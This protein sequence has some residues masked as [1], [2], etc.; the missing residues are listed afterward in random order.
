MK[1]KLRLIPLLLAAAIAMSA[2]SGGG[3]Q[4]TSA[5]T[6]HSAAAIPVEVMTAEPASISK[7][8]TYVGKVAAN[9]TVDV[10]SKLSAQAKE[11]LVDVGDTVKKGQVLLILDDKDLRDQIKTSEAQLKVAN[12]GVQTA[13]TGLEQVTSGGQTA[14]QKLSLETAVK[15]AQ[16][17]VDNA[18]ISMENAKSSV[19]TSKIA[20]DNAQ[21]AFNDTQ[22][23]Y[24]D[25]KTMLDAGVI[26]QSDF[27]SIELGYNQ[28]KNALEQAQLGYSQTENAYNQAKNAYDTACTALEQAQSSLALFNEKTLQD[29]KENARNGVASANASRD[30]VL[31]SLNVLKSNLNYIQ[32]T[33]PIDGVITK[34]NVEPTNMVSAG[35]APF[36]VADTSKV[37]VNVD[38]SEKI[39]NS[40]N[41]GQTIGVNI[42]SVYDTPVNGVIKTIDPAAGSNGAF[43]V[44]IEIANTDGKLKP[45]M[46]AHVSFTEQESDN[47]F[48]V[49][50]NTVLEDNETKYVYVIDGVTAVK[51]PVTT[52]IDN[53]EN[54]EIS[55]VQSGDKIVVSGQSYLSDG[56][57]VIL[58]EE[59]EQETT[60]AGKEE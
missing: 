48:V 27:D 18:K 55:G 13:K 26:T 28:A 42:N 45:G 38:V 12:A 23:K 24:N 58:A 9:D 31:E 51:T 17:G 50:R 29:S 4:E 14:T 41:V 53:G 1:K 44:K 47:V 34:R 54:I 39:I 19:S 10:T 11:V 40:I 36:V 8:L 7:Y 15:N 43:T 5:Q 35:L 6:E 49:P 25:Y 20:M 56:S 22:K 2:C 30:S 46:I 3:S 60:T 32:V 16:T 52:G 37:T 59:E 57:S 33:S 21:N